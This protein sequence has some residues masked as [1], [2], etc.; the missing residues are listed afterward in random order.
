MFLEPFCKISGR[1][2]NVF[3]IT[4]IFTAFISI[5]D[6][7]FVCDRILVLGS[8]KRLLI[9]CPPR[10]PEC[11][12]CCMSLFILSLSPRWYGTTMYKVCFVVVLANGKNISHGQE[13][14]PLPTSG[15]GTT[16]H[17]TKSAKQ[18]TNINVT[19]TS[20]T[21]INNNK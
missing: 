12:I 3:F 10:T 1:F 13:K 4:P 9:V 7:T 18:Y 16:P 19:I 5:Y 14:Y 8:H 15:G 21:K 2:S 17:G 11:Q 6:S 20:V